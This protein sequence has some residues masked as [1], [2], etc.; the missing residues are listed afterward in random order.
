MSLNL[1]N[2]TNKCNICDSSELAEVFKTLDMPLTGLYLDQPSSMNEF[3]N[4]QILLQCE[5]CGHAQLKYI[6]S[7]NDLYDTSYTHR[8]TKSNI[9]YSGNVFFHNYLREITHSRSK[10]NF[11]NILE[12]G[13]NDLVLINQIQDLGSK[14]T[15]I[16]PIWRDNDFSLNEKTEVL[17]CFVDEIDSYKKVIGSPDLILSAHTFEHVDRTFQQFSKLT[18]IASDDCLFI[19]EMPSYDTLIKTGRFDQVFHQHLQY[20]SL[21]S[22]LALVDRLDC[23]YI[24]HT[25]NY[26][27]W[28]GTFLFAFQKSSRKVP[29]NLP[30]ANKIIHSD[31]T[32]QFLNFKEKLVENVGLISSADEPVYGFGAA[33]MLP[34]IA[35]HL[36]SDLSFMKG[37]IDDNESRIGTY[38]PTINCPTV[39]SESVSNLSESICVVTAIDSSR[40]ILKRILDLNPRRI[41]QLFPVI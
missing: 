17:G 20:I 13:C 3:C 16:D 27:Y 4:D 38:L 39:S 25:Y 31:V 35:H 5:E 30:T 23:K 7:P 12:I 24:G 14:I 40:P 15:G 26:A 9:S 1:V 37:I 34:I 18:Q 6:I 21:Q 2:I 8:S 41:A 33:Q 36:G 29:N 22:M 19:I 10:D 28:G 32:K 11:E